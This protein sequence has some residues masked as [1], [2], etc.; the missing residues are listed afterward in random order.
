VKRR[1]L[2][3]ADEDLREIERKVAEGDVAALKR[4]Y[5]VSTRLGKPLDPDLEERALE[6]I[7]LDGELTQ[8]EIDTR[9][10]ER[11]AA[12][13]RTKRELWLINGLRTRPESVLEDDGSWENTGN[14]ELDPVIASKIALLMRSVDLNPWANVP[15]DAMDAIADL[16]G[17]HVDAFDGREEPLYV[18]VSWD[19]WD[20]PTLFYSFR[21]KRFSIETTDAVARRCRPRD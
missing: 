19:D 3:S 17:G 15:T 18:Y 21:R 4:L 16:L 10:A 9:R 7:L 2:N 11:L 12:G 14:Q 6:Q 5:V 1:K 20:R 8:S 13:R